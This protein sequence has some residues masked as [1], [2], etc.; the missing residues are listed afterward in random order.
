MALGGEAGARLASRLAIGTSPDTLLRAV[1]S[2]GGSAP[3]APTPRV[4]GV[5]DWAWRRGGCYGTALVDLERNA[6]VELLPDRQA[7]TLA[8]WLRQ[9]PGVEV[10]ARDRT[11]AYADGAR[12]GAPG[13]VQ[14]GRGLTPADASPCAAPGEPRPWPWPAAA[15]VVVAGQAKPGRLRPPRPGAGLA[16]RPAVPGRDR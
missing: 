3:A 9:H 7:E 14:V 5:D 13:A 15:W 4:L 2:G 11:G 8:I 16:R 6:V 10:I 12:Q 1:R